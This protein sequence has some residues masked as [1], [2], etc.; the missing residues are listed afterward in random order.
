VRLGRGVE[1][2]CDAGRRGLMGAIAAIGAVIS[3][4]FNSDLDLT[5]VA[6]P[7][8]LSASREI[9]GERCRNGQSARQLN[10]PSAHHIR[11]G[12]PLAG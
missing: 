1:H 3:A 11:S 2:R 7:S 4:Q 12:L 6:R 8:P 9:S 10:Y 5:A